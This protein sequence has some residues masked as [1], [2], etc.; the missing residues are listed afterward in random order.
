[1]LQIILFF[2]YVKYYAIAADVAI[3]MTTSLLFLPGDTQK[4]ECHDGE[5]IYTDELYFEIHSI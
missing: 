5:G 1:M 2:I 4:I 3:L